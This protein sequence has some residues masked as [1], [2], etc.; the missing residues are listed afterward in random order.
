MNITVVFR[1][2]LCG[3]ENLAFSSAH[4]V[5]RATDVNFTM[6]ATCSLGS[7]TEMIFDYGFCSGVSLGARALRSRR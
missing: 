7:S 3:R 5:R 1:N 4:E 2:V 6:Y